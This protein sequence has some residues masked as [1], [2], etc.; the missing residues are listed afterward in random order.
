[1]IKRLSM[2][3]GSDLENALWTVSL[4]IHNYDYEDQEQFIHFLSNHFCNIAPSV[5]LRTLT[6]MLHWYYYNMNERIKSLYIEMLLALSDTVDIISGD[7]FE[8]IGIIIKGCSKNDYHRIVSFINNN[9]RKCFDDYS[10]VISLCNCIRYSYPELD[11]EGKNILFSILNYLEQ[12]FQGTDIY[13]SIEF[14]INSL[15]DRDI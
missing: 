1:M 11:S 9:Y 12:R 8:I 5:M 6:N 14:T 7:L 15:E 2:L 10:S 13:P 3:T 4:S